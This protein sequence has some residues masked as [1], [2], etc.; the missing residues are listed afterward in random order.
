MITLFTSNMSGGIIQLAVQLLGTISELHKEVC[1]FMPK[2]TV[3]SVP[4]A[5]Y[6]KVHFYEKF[7]TLNPIDRRL[8]I[9]ADAV[10]D[11]SPE[12]IWY[13]DSSILSLEVSLQIRN[14]TK[15]LLTLHDAGTWHPSNTVNLRKK[16]QM[17]YSGCLINRSMKAVSNI[18][19]LSEESRKVCIQQY[20]HLSDKIMLMTLGAHIPDIKEKMPEELSDLTGTYFLFFGRIDKYKGIKGMCDT[21]S[22]LDG[23]KYPLVIAGNGTLAMDEQIAINADTN[24][25]L[26][27]R[28][29]SDKE[30]IW[31]FKH[32]KAV[33]LPYIE[34]TQSGI[35]PIAYKYGLPVVISNVPGLM[36]FVDN[37]KTGFVC[38]TG[39]DYIHAF[40]KMDDEKNYLR[41]Q[42]YCLN[43][44]EMYL[45][46]NANVMDLI[47]SI[48]I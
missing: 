22:Q 48:G 14:R 35:I 16:I 43:Y 21:Y 29:I 18:L 24:I 25:T 47:K 13:V 5:L 23:K 9:L 8:K 32:A 44:S 20:P 42:S 2:G 19:V 7:K 15:Q 36:Q 12:L 1:C 38:S 33:I 45:S 41:M 3:A 4:D 17:K 28:Y 46:W 26:I 27:N 11:T 37:G 10:L 6:P 40:K 39:H 30:M 34:A 31:L